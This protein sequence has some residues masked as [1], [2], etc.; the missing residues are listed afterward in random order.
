MIVFNIKQYMTH[1]MLN[2]F[3]ENYAACPCDGSWLI[4]GVQMGPIWVSPIYNFLLKHD[5]I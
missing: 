2:H 4:A 1:F 5:L 3:I